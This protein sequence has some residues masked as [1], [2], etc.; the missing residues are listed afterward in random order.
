M[1]SMHME[2]II[3]G[4]NR[5]TV[6]A[7]NVSLLTHTSGEKVRHQNQNLD[8]FS[9]YDV[10][11]LALLAGSIYFITGVLFYFFHKNP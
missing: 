2:F 9:F 3:Q 10:S 5:I 6:L 4:N 8:I 11:K 1:H 7:V